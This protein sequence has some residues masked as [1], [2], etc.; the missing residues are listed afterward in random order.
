MTISRVPS[1]TTKVVNARNGFTLVEL[2]VVIALMAGLTA[3]LL[4]GLGASGKNTVIQ[5]AQAA[6]AGTITVARTKAM[7]SGQPCR[8][9]VNIDPTSASDPARYLR[10]VV[11]QVR[12]STGWRTITDL[13]LPTEVYFVPGDFVSLPAG[14]FSEGA[15]VWVRADATGNLRSTVLRSGQISSE[16]INSA[17]AEQ[18]V[19]FSI[20]PV[21]TTGQAGDLVLA[22]GR[23]RQPG[24]YAEGESPIELHRRDSVCGVSLSTYGL[25]VL[26]GDQSGF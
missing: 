12:T 19:S 8:L 23:P 17:A 26:I 22:L 4:G 21:G 6:L 10:Y 7:S 9:M 1:L 13:Y 14:L 20:S 16:A 25:A 2:L 18:W 11:V 24:T 15:G 5:S 3:M